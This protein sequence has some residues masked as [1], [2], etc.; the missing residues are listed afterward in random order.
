M[1]SPSAPI[2]FRLAAASDTTTTDAGRP[3]EGRGYIL[4]D[5][6]TGEPLG[7]DDFFFRIGGG[8]VCDLTH[9][10]RYSLALQQAC[11]DPGETLV[12]VRGHLGDGT[13]A[14]E[15]RDSSA[16]KTVGRLPTEVVEAIGLHRDGYEAA[17]SLWEWRNQRG[18]R[19]GLRVLLAP[20]WTTDR[21]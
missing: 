13:P 17:F 16:T 7:D 20:G 12:L 18:R 4:C 14:I 10:G 8:F 21:L 9:T 11:F 5:P 6:Q 3:L 19:C 15:V 2:Q 1:V